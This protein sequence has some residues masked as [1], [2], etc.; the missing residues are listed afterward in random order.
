MAGMRGRYKVRLVLL[1]VAVLLLGVGRQGQAPTPAALPPGEEPG[2]DSGA[3]AQTADMDIHGR[4]GVYLTAYSLAKPGFLL[5]I[6]D[7]LERFGLDTVVINVKDM[8]GEVSYATG[9]ELAHRIGAAVPRLPLA[10]ILAEVH[11]R[12]MYAIARQVVFYD[13]LLAGFLGS[14]QPPWV[15]PTE[16]AV[17][18]NLAIARELEQLGFDEVQFDYVRFPDDGPIGLDYS[19]RS[20]A[21]EAFLAQAQGQLSVPISVDVFGRVLWPWNAR[22]IDPIGQHLEGMA[23]HVDLFSPML[24]PSH[25]VEQELK[26]DP[27]GTVRRA[28]E[29]GMARVTTPMR[30]FLQAFDMA[31]PAGMTLPQYI[32]AQLRAAEEMGADGYLFWHPGSD[33][34]ALWAA[35]ELLGRR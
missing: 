30:P 35:L 14:P 17:V 2:L 20:V 19:A 21:V 22:E 11:G 34:N 9:V 33:Y 27:H 8:H 13:P 23:P 26:D 28:L 6:L 25:Y 5:G 15:L 12:G 32:V 7:R 24:Y 10:A 16:K 29:Y 1:L 3:Q 4:R 31:I 18:Y